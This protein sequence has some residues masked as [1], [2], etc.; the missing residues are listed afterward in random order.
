MDGVLS[1][2][3]RKDVTLSRNR[4][5][6]RIPL[7]ALVLFV[8]AAACGFEMRFVVIG[9][10]SGMVGAWMVVVSR[11]RERRK[12]MQPADTADE[13]K[14]SLG[15]SEDEVVIESNRWSDRLRWNRVTGLWRFP[16]YWILFRDEQR[17]VPI[18]LVCLSQQEQA[19]L[20][21]KIGRIDRIVEK[22]WKDLFRREES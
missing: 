21:R 9:V 10:V 17:L 7:A 16:D 3:Q 18:R 8:L 22:G 11:D 5:F 20:T 2:I 12:L 15:W 4:A 14:V 13:L 6:A 19:W 1:A